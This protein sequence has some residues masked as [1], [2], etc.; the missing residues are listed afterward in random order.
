MFSFSELK[1]MYQASPLWVQKLYSSIPFDCRA[2]KVYRETRALIRET[3]YLSEP[4]LQDRQIEN[5]QTLLVHC[6]Q[7]V[8][9]WRDEMSRI[10]FNPNT[11]DVLN[12]LERLPMVDKSDLASNPDGYRAD[13]TCG[14]RVYKDNTGGSSGTPMAFFKNNSMYPKELAYMLAQWERVGYH[15]R[16]PKLTLRGRTF[17]GLDTDQ[18]WNINPIYNEIAL[19]TYH[20]DAMTLAESMKPVRRVE[21][22]FIHSYPSAIV[23]FLQ[24]LLDAGIGLPEGIQAVLCGSEPLYDHQRQFI[25]DTL[26]C[27]C[28]SWYGQSECV[29]LAGEC[30]HSQQYHSYPLYGVMELVDENNQVIRVPNVEGE[31]VGTSLHNIATPFVRYRTGDRGILADGKCTCGR[32]H[33]RLKQVTGRTQYLIYTQDMTPVPSTAFVF[34]QHFAA[35]EHI[36]GIQLVQDEPGDLLVRIVRRDRFSENDEREIR[37]KMRQCVDSK[38]NIRFEYQLEL[39]VNKAGKVDFV[40]QN[41]AP[42]KS[43]PVDSASP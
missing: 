42:P 6:Q 38:L 37:D 26:G 13:H 14:E 1:R 39:P 16:H 41:V 43:I 17:A 2:G 12:G 20:L 36:R 10:G 22:K 27:R 28:Y 33:S 34:G 35:F 40:I 30:E 7:H 32:H 24:V 9:I 5:L 25:T 31:I 15:P 11:D 29:I 19:S 3:D 21:P 23:A 18:R 8:P 4:Q